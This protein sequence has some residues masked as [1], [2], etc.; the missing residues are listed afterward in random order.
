MEQSK[1]IKIFKFIVLL[2]ACHFLNRN[3]ENAYLIELK[4]SVFTAEPK[5]KRTQKQEC[6]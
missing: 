1:C 3:L 4:D 2:I 5:Q 6:N